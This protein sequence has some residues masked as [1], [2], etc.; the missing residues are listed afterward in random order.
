MAQLSS[1]ERIARVEQAPVEVQ[2]MVAKVLIGM[3]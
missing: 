3:I 1:E 2:V